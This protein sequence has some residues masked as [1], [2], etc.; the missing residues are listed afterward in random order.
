MQSI[1]Y[2][3]TTQTHVHGCKARKP[4][5]SAGPTLLNTHLHSFLLWTNV[6]ETEEPA[7]NEN[8]KEIASWSYFRWRRLKTK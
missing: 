3:S 7:V 5:A 6:L 2:A 1:I 8:D 4:T